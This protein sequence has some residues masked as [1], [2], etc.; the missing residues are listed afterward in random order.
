MEYGSL[1]LW[2]LQ[3]VTRGTLL[4]A[5]CPSLCA[6]K[7]TVTLIMSFLIISVT[8]SDMYV[9]REERYILLIT[10]WASD[11]KQTALPGQWACLINN[12]HVSR[13]W[14]HLKLDTKA[15]VSLALCVCACVC[16]CVYQSTVS[17]E[18]WFL[19]GIYPSD[20]TQSRLIVKL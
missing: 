1:R 18:W 10:R 15:S 14:K 12:M 17:P 7:S 20:S 11:D 9:Q 16:V 13:H 5:P 19:I 3:P 4:T 6:H 2:L 8:L